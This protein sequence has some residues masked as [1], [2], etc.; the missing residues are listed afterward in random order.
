MTTLSASLTN[1]TSLLPQSR[2]ISCYVSRPILAPPPLWLQKHADLRAH[3]FAHSPDLWRKLR[4]AN[5]TCAWSWILCGINPAILEPCYRIVGL[6]MALPPTDVSVLVERCML[7]TN[8]KV[9]SNQLVDWLTDWWIVPCNIPQEWRL[10]LCVGGRSKPHI[11][12]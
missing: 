12:N 4:L 10:Q 9:Q 2:D 8:P 6:L 11:P 5:V 1:L 3:D 7:A